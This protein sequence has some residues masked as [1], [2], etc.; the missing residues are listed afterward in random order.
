MYIYM[1]NSNRNIS[2]DPSVDMDKRCRRS[3]K[4]SGAE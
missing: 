1:T 3:L 4:N 2:I